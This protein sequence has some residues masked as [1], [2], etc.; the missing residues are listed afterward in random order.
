[1]GRARRLLFAVAVVALL[2]WWLSGD[3]VPAVEPGSV[4]VVELGG[5]YV[6][7]PQIP[8]LA[9]LLGEEQRPLISLLS[10][11]RKAARDPRIGAV[12]VRVRNLQIGWAK[13]QEIR[14]GIRHL[15]EGGHR[16]VSLLD[17]EAF[18]A[19]LEYYVASAAPEVYAT[20]AARAP[21]LGLAGEY[22]FLGGLWE[23]IGVEL[24]VE[25]IGRFKTAAETLAARGMSAANRE[26]ANSLL[27]SLDA[28]L[29]G[30]IAEARGLSDSE[31]RAAID[32][33]AVDPAE[34]QAQ[35]LLDGIRELDELVE[36]LGD[37]PVLYG[38]DY[39][40]VSP[41]SAGIEPVARFALIYGSGGVVSG[42]GSRDAAGTP[43]LASDTVGEALEEAA[44]EPSF[45]ALIFRIDS[46]GGSALASDSVFRALRRAQK[47]GKPVVASFSDVAASGGYYVA[48]GADAIVASPATLTGS[49]GVFALR[50]VL[51]GLYDKL[52]IGFETLTRG[53]HAA[54][55]LSARPLS[56]GDRARLQA[57]VRSI[58]ELFVERVAQGRSMQVTAVDAMARGR[59]YTGAQAL[60]LGLVDELGGLFA[61]IARAKS[62]LGIDAEADVE[63]V[64]YPPPRTLFEEITLG[65]NGAAMSRT[66]LEILEARLDA[67]A[68]WLGALSEGAPV[69]LLPFPFEVH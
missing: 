59:V 22:L 25:R 69:A 48:A 60:E 1:M 28:Q 65:L 67:L 16:V 27:D 39:A 2:F 30:G 31:V 55:Q 24:E 32:A 13:A 40:R 11:F 37:G 35:G 5:S 64:P 50:P 61:A 36:V 21:L 18:G 7:A 8:L 26:M 49:I 29:L 3:D 19:N 15:S 58:Y 63:L 45:D 42:R 33:A 53:R 17:L 12:I 54:L 52:G 4:L 43:V 66:G 34:Q 20:P 44:A 10:D 68:P 6:D 41:A 62:A 51:G 9:R 57:Q 46:P 38:H 14:A 56:E 23:S 47:E